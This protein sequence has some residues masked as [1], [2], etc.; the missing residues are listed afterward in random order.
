MVIKVSLK[1]NPRFR[2]KNHETIYNRINQEISNEILFKREELKFKGFE[3][4]LKTE[5]LV[6][7]EGLSTWIYSDE[8][9]KGWAV[10]TYLLSVVD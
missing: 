10:P 9:G 6:E 4:H 8:L 2:H 3:I 7:I 1:A 5:E